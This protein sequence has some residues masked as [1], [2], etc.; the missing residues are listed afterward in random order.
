MTDAPTVPGTAR[1]APP[2]R[3]SAALIVAATLA[4]VAAA[5]TIGAMFPD[6]WDAPQLALIDQ[7][8]PLA[9]T[10]VFAAALLVGGALLLGA[11]SALLGAAMLAIVVAFGVQPRAVDVVRLSQSSGP[12]AGTGFALIT[13]GFVLALVAAL[14][15]AIVLLRPREWSLGGGARPLAALGA[16]AG[17][18]AAVGYGMNPFSTNGRRFDFGFGSPLTPVSRQLWAAL[19]VVVLLTVVPPVAVAVGGRIGSGLALGLLFGIAG[20]AAFRLGEIYGSID[21]RDTGYRGAEGTWT[22]LAA[23]GAALIMT[24]AGLAGGTSRRTSSGPRRPVSATAPIAPLAATP[25]PVATSQ[26]VPANDD[27]TEDGTTPAEPERV[28]PMPGVASARS[29]DA[30]APPAAEAPAGSPAPEGADS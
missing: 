18:G 6:Y 24:W 8:G 11:R 2:H 29:D 19:L 26:P 22:F 3:H 7:T 17:F 15:A 1:P 25:T 14:L 5:L 9:Q 10:A 28:D 23:G 27:W 13:A 21:G 12:R 30:G 4:F 20:I 16:L